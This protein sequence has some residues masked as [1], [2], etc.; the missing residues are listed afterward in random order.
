MHATISGSPVNLCFDAEEIGPWVCDGTGGTWVSGRGT[1][2]GRKVG[3]RLVAGVL[4]EDWNGANVSCHI[5]GDGN[6]ANREFLWAIFAYPF[7]QLGVRR[8]TGLVD[9][10]NKVANEF[11]LRLGFVLECSLVGATPSGNLNIYRMTR[12]EC[13]FLRLPHGQVEKSSAA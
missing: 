7:N 4:Y 11:N 6:W 2:I 13:R 12:D 10:A 1:A 9:S 5:R 8:L 3:G